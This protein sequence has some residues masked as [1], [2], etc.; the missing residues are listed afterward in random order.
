MKARSFLAGVIVGGA[1]A[2]VAGLVGTTLRDTPRPPLFASLP[3][4]TVDIAPAVDRLVKA[5]FPAGTS[6][7]SAIA[8]LSKM[9]FV[10]RQGENGLW[11]D[12]TAGGFLCTESFLVTWEPAE[13]RS[14][15]GASG[16]YRSS[17]L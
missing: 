7:D 4:K 10:I 2:F 3:S 1:I 17:C 11:A 12:Y 5:E 15:A 14:I 16:D 9:G 8:A 13:G 6:Q